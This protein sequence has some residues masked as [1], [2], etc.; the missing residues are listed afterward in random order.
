MEGKE[1]CGHGV[2]ETASKCSRVKIWYFLD[3][4]CSL[5]GRAVGRP[6][7]RAASG[8]CRDTGAA[9]GRQSSDGA[10]AW[11]S[12]APRHLSWP[13]KY[14]SDSC[15]TWRKLEEM[16]QIFTYIPANDLREGEGGFLCLSVPA[17]IND[18][19]SPQILDFSKNRCASQYIENLK[20]GILSL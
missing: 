3:R 20:L 17:W 9:L 2:P 13:W 5:C 14:C 19:I 11:R 1:S 10:A 15:L 16:C 12:A 6:G 7:C 18:F 4:R 8:P